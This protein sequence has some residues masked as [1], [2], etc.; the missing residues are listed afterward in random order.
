[1]GENMRCLVLGIVT[2]VLWG[3]ALIPPA[4]V[5]SISPSQNQA[6]ITDI[7][8]TLTPRNLDVFEPRPDAARALRALAD[9]GYKIVYLTT[10]IPLYQS[11]LSD[12]LR[13]NGFPVGVLHVAQTAQERASPAEYKAAVLA[14]YLR[15]GWRLEYAYGDSSTDF[16]AY[17]K[18]GMP[19]QRVFAL[20]RKG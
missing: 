1:M 9:K 3:C 7:D 6:V 10:R 13:Q 2:L 15:A 4:D 20:K 5:P 16:I 18:A 12:W 8:G 14:G 11:G 17:A 19:K